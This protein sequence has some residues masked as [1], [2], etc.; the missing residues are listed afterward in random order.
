MKLNKQF[1]SHTHTHSY[2]WNGLVSTITIFCWKIFFSWCKSQ[3]KQE[4][5]KQIFLMRRIFFFKF[6]MILFQ[7]FSSLCFII[8]QWPFFPSLLLI[9]FFQQTFFSLLII[10]FSFSFSSC[11]RWL[12]FGRTLWLRF[13]LFSFG[14]NF[15]LV[16]NHYFFLVLFWSLFLASFFLPNDNNDHHHHWNW[17]RK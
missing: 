14:F 16:W 10:N 8:S 1:Y 17:P 2:E 13:F 12:L 3:I 9:S 5:A 6:S 4:T 15:F 11:F 7:F